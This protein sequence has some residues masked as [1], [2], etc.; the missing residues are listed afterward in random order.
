MVDAAGFDAKVKPILQNTCSEC[1]NASYA[2][3]DLNLT[4][5]LNPATVL[6]DRAIWEKIARKIEAGEMPPA[7]AE[8]PAKERM[9]ALV[10]FVRGQFDKADALVKPD[11]R[12]GDGEAPQPQ[13]VSQYHPRPAGRRLPCR[14]G[15]PDRRFRIWL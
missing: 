12:P 15:F 1:H 2:S 7:G 14:P 10:E 11:P 9:A 5:F 13:R 6:E 4:P 3:G 8:R